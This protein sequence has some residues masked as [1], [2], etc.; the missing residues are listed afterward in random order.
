M[1]IVLQRVT[2]ASVKIEEKNVAKIGNGLLVLL[3]IT[4]DDNQEDINW[5]VK[6]IINLRIFSDT[7]QKMNLS[8]LDTKGDLIVV[9]QFTLF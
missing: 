2:S 9:S 7:A 3:G 1:R 5:L 6:K 4:A 8:I